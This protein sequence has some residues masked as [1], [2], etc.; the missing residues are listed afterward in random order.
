MPLNFM[1][2]RIWHILIWREKGKEVP[3]FDPTTFFF[4]SL[5]RY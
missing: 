2:G 1:V 5:R 4:E 3:A